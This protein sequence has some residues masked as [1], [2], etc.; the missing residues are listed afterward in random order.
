MNSFQAGLIRSMKAFIPNGTAALG[1]V[2]ENCGSHN[3]IYEGGCMICRDCGSS[4]CG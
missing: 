2:C 3:I 1:A 4:H